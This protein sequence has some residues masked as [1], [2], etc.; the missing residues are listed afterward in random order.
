MKEYGKKGDDYISIK[1]TAINNQFTYLFTLI[2]PD[3]FKDDRP[4]I[5]SPKPVGCSNMLRDEGKYLVYGRLGFFAVDGSRFSVEDI[6]VK[7][8]KQN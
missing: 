3:P 4:M 2:N 7:P 1:V 6:E 8:L 5:K